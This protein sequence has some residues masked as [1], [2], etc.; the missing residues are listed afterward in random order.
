MMILI[1]ILSGVIIYAIC[2]TLHM[3][4]EYLDF[5]APSKA[6]KKYKKEVET[7][8]NISGAEPNKLIGLATRNWEELHMRAIAHAEYML[9]HIDSSK[10]TAI[11]KIDLFKYYY[12]NYINKHK[13]SFS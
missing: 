3:F 2:L 12:R 9:A 7:K 5:E 6:E 1:I 13:L 8:Y 11:E 10:L 4:S